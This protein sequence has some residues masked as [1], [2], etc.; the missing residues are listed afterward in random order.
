MAE[1]NNDYYKILGVDKNATDSQIKKAYKK[2]AMKHHPDKQTGKSEI[3]KAEAEEKFKQISEAYQILSD[4]EQRKTYDRFGKRGLDGHVHTG[5]QF[6]NNDA[7]NIFEQ[8]FGGSG[9]GNSFGPGTSFRFGTNSNNFEDGSTFNPDPM[10]VKHFR[11]AQQRR[12]AP[13]KGKNSELEYEIS[14]QDFYTGCTKKIKIYYKIGLVKVSDIVEVDIQKGWRE[15]IKITYNGKS[16]CP[17]GCLP[18]DLSLILVE[19]VGEH[20]FRRRIN[21]S[22]LL[23]TD[24]DGTE[25]Q[26]NSDLVY[27][28]NIS[29][30]EAQ[31]GINKT[32]THM[33]GRRVQVKCPKL[34]TSNQEYQIE[35]EGM[36]IRSKGRVV[37]KGELYVRFNIIF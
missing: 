5:A 27:T 19:K 4:S 12:N 11:N 9:F 2:L 1:T 10:N 35:N 28:L 34:N 17:E 33:D 15:G 23:Y 3:Q 6:S 30:E 7:F 22:P 26:K 8:F 20:G 25:S 32:I 36:P 37:G 29:L 31:N 21:E 13:R 18:G 24:N 14:L 16:S